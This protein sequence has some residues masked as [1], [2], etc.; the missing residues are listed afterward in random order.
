MV[1][2][3]FVAAVAGLMDSADAGVANTVVEEVIEGEK[4]DIADVAAIEVIAVEEKEG[5][6]GVVEVDVA[7]AKVHDGGKKRPPNLE[8]GLRW[9]LQAQGCFEKEHRGYLPAQRRC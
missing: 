7:A 3:R 2:T 4:A 6:V 5:I 1:S 8:E 9:S